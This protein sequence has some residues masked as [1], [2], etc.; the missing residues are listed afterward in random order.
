MV[1]GQEVKRYKNI[2]M[3]DMLKEV[4]MLDFHF[5]VPENGKVTFEINYAQGVLPE[6]LKN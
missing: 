4:E 6:V 2:D 5:N 1:E 3:P